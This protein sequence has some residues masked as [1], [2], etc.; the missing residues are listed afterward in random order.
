M[1]DMK[2]I[3]L[4]SRQQALLMTKLLAKSMPVTGNG[5]FDALLTASLDEANGAGSGQAASLDKM[6]SLQHLQAAP[7]QPVVGTA[8][9]SMFKEILG[10]VLKHE[11]S[12]YVHKD[13]GRESSKYG[14]LQSTA[15]QYGYKG[16]IKHIT[17]ADA[18][19][20]YKKIWDRSGAASLP[21]PLSLIHFDTYVN[22]PAAAVKLLKKS[23]GGTEAYLSMRSR[24][25]ARLA[26]L[27]PER[28]ARYLKGWMNRVADLRN[29]AAQYAA[30]FALNSVR[31]SGESEG[32]NTRA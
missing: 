20:V 19:A 14:I 17:R 18:E 3:A 11:G 27:R 30:N 21:Y 16:N 7:P 6:L 4:D 22:S 1:K 32:K 25:Y 31:P 28:Y 26:E 13:G 15:R 29:I 10:V 24:R 12:A 8:D 2:N 23:G 9:K 5:S